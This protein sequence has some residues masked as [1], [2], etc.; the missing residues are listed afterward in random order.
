MYKTVNLGCVRGRVVQ[1]LACLLPAG[2]VAGSSPAVLLYI[3]NFFTNIGRDNKKKLSCLIRKVDF[4]YQKGKK[5]L[6][7]EIK[8][9]ETL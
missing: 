9:N 2:M 1:W 4:F 8:L 3:E 5:K 7:S 6:T